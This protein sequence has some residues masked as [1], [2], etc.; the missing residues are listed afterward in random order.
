[1]RYVKH[2]E[3]EVARIRDKI[4]ASQT[5]AR[6]LEEENNEMRSRL[7]AGAGHR[8]QSTA[9]PPENVPGEL[10][11]DRSVSFSDQSQLNSTGG[12]AMSL[13]L[14]STMN[15]PVYQVGGEPRSRVYPANT[16]T[17]PLNTP[18]HTWAPHCSFSQL[19]PEQE[20]QI[21]NFILA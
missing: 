6:L 18:E 9:S 4:E 3:I 8:Q 20:Q 16:H 12:V 1:M 13:G 7:A 19:T 10:P 5:E 2:L 14:D 21:V 15:L 11:K 17:N